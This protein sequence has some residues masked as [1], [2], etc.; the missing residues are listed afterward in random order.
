MAGGALEAQAVSPL[1]DPTAV[2]DIDAD[3]EGMVES[4]AL[5]AKPKPDTPSREEIEQHRAA[6]H[7]PFRSWCRCCVA[8][9][10]RGDRHRAKEDGEVAC[11][12]IDYGYLHERVDLTDQEAQ[13][14]GSSPLLVMRDKWT[15][16]TMAE[17]VQSKGVTHVW[18]EKVFAEM[19]E[20][21]GYHKLRLLSDGEPSIIA[22]K[23]KAVK[24]LRETR[25]VDVLTE[26]T[27]P[28]DHQANGLAES[29][30]R[31]VKAQFRVLKLAIEDDYGCVLDRESPILSWV[32]R[33]AG[34]ALTRGSV[35]T[36][37]KTPFERLQGHRYRRQLPPLCKTVM[38]KIRDGDPSRA[39]P[40]WLKGIF[41]GTVSKSNE[42]YIGIADAVTKS[43]SVRRLAEHEQHD[44]DLLRSVKGTPWMLNPKEEHP[45]E[46][47][48]LPGIPMGADADLPPRVP[49]VELEAR[50]V[51]MRANVELLKYGYTLNCPGCDAARAGLRA[52]A[53][54]E[55]CRRR[56]EDAM[57]ADTDGTARM[58]EAEDRARRRQE[59]KRSAEEILQGDTTRVRRDKEAAPSG[60][61]HSGSRGSMDLSQLASGFPPDDW[62]SGCR[63]LS[64]L[65]GNTTA[66]CW[67][68]LVTRLSE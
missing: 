58:Q 63:A 12:G 4:A 61:A 25:R 13:D 1:E 43:R 36:D 28:D 30:V 17:V 40:R 33:A 49:R 66:T 21:L 5:R 42:L 7:V 32:V 20:T 22:L 68:M 15:G 41:L 54:S 6:G 3:D 60:D 19:L 8:G 37:G 26:T 39:E 34:A 51:Y 24:Y 52:R 18:S 11:V 9:K 10:G 35:G 56:L 50:R 45:R 14:Q 2:G 23:E 46:L 47:I 48:V 16:V 27:A 31:D 64:K 55:D 57:R 67:R 65:G 44:L 59:A 29:A 38:Y 53:R 62:V